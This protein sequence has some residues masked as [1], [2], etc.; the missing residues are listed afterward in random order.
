MG[1]RPPPRRLA[2]APSELHPDGRR[3]LG[4]DG[5]TASRP[6]RSALAR[7]EGPLRRGPE[8]GALLSLCGGSPPL[9]KRR[10]AH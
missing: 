9:P 1:S 7:G 6:R 4:A 5:G 8:G 2:E 3:T 10:V